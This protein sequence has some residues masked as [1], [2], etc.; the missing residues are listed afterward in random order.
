MPEVLQ[1]FMQISPMTHF[2]SMA[3]AILYRGAGLETVW[4]N[5]VWLVGV[6]AVYFLL[7]LAFFRKSLASAQ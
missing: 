3:Q 2:V 6:G 5:M 4:P 1:D 7:A